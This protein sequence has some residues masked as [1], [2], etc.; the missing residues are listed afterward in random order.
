M[1][2]ELVGAPVGRREF[3]ALVINRYEARK[4]DEIERIA[5][6]VRAL[7]EKL[8][9]DHRASD[10]A[11]FKDALLK[12]DRLAQ[13]LQVA[14]S[15]LGIDEPHSRD[16]FRSIREHCIDLANN[17]SQNTLA[18]AILE[19]GKPVF[20][21]LPDASASIDKDIYALK[22]LA[23]GERL[24]AALSP[25]KLLVDTASRDFAKLG[26]EVRLPRIS[27]QHKA[28][29]AALD[30]ALSSG[31]PET[32]AIAVAMI[33]GLAIK[34]ANDV[35]DNSG[36]LAITTSLL[37]RQGRLPSE[38]TAQLQKDHVALARNISFS[39]MMDALKSGN[40][41][42][43]KTLANSLAANADGE[44]ARSIQNILHLISERQKKSRNGWIW[45]A[46]ILGGIVAIIAL[47]EKN[48]GS[49]SNYDP[50]SQYND[51]S[52]AGSVENILANT[53]SNSEEASIENKIQNDGVA[54]D[55]EVS[56]KENRPPLYSIGTSFDRSQ[57]RYCMMQKARLEAANNVSARPTEY[58][59]QQFNLTVDDYN[60]RCSNFRYHNDD[61]TAVQQE[62][63]ENASR[64]RS[65]GEA[66]VD[67]GY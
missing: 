13:P 49:V 65:E 25:L 60:S 16:L 31:D 24:E 12:W 18:M 43:A 44:E 34:L 30:E 53:E 4:G 40:L 2:K 23:R 38:T 27:H 45:T 37:Q 28:I 26:R 54:A 19:I 10:I 56:I 50:P 62:V 58:K 52:T 17:K 59:I 57:V 14:D 29:M 3:I 63:N 20:N 11:A 51:T 1:A 7:L 33:R 47:S 39:N 46:V 64:L 35:E 67:G 6:D 15:V 21:E 22:D 42:H 66:L 61:M 5:E 32:S 55:D 8:D 36:A 41:S 48:S 9:G